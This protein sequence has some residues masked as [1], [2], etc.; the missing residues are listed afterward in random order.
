M[1]PDPFR[2][3]GLHFE[4]HKL[5]CKMYCN[6]WIPIQIYFFKSTDPDRLQITSKNI[7]KTWSYCFKIQEK[8]LD[9]NESL[10]KGSGTDHLK[11]RISPDWGSGLVEWNRENGLVKRERESWR[12]LQELCHSSQIISITRGRLTQIMQR[13][14]RSKPKNVDRKPNVWIVENHVS[15]TTKHVSGQHNLLLGLKNYISNCFLVCTSM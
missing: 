7:T 8:K 2:G 5:Y 13:W 15:A 14:Y 4:I 3:W 6:A 9:R 10:P 12:T 1:E 11:K